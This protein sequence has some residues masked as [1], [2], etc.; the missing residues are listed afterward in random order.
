M[1]KKRLKLVKI[2]LFTKAQTIVVG[3]LDKEKGLPEPLLVVSRESS[4]CNPVYEEERFKKLLDLK[5]K[6]ARTAMSKARKQTLAELGNNFVYIIDLKK[7][8]NKYVI[9]KNKHKGFPKSIYIEK[10]T[11]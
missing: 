1:M 4:V 9:F 8:L 11:L 3:G 7:T 2:S 5:Q 10:K 6:L